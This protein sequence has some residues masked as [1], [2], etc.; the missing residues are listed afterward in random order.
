MSSPYEAGYAARQRGEPHNP[1]NSAE[2]KRGYAWADQMIADD[3][4]TWRDGDDWMIDREMEA[5]G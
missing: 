4:D 2:W 1:R 3:D 5:K